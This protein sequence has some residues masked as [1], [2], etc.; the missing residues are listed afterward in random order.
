LRLEENLDYNTL[1]ILFPTLG[2]RIEVS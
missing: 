1:F 2:K